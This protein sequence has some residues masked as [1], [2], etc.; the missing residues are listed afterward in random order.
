MTSHEVRAGVMALAAH[1]GWSCREILGM[2]VSRFLWW[3]E[4]LPPEGGAR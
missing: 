1:T 2:P 4:G 3:W